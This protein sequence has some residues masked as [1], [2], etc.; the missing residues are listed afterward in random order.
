MHGQGA[1]AAPAAAPAPVVIQL[2][3]QTTAPAQTAGPNWGQTQQNGTRAA[4]AGST[5][6]TGADAVQSTPGSNSVPDRPTEFQQLVV[7]TTGT[8]LPVFGSD[9]F[10]NAPSTFAPV[11]SAQVTSDYLIGPGDEIRLSATGQLDQQGSFVV[12]RAGTI[13]IPQVGTLSVSGLHFSELQPFLKSQLGRIY[14]NFD[15]TVTLGQLRSIQIYV[16][17]EARRPGAYTVS[18]LSTLLNALFASGGVLP[19]GTL[20][21]IQLLRN[22][23]VVTRFDLYDILLRGD[24]SHDVTLQPGD[25]I[26]IPKAGPQVAVIGSVTNPAIYEL[27]GETTVDRLLAL[28]NGLTSTAAGTNARIESIYNHQQHTITD[29]DLRTSATTDLRDGDILTVASVSDEFKDA[30]TLRGNVTYPGRY[31]W[32]AG[33]R[34]SDLIR[35]RE[36]LRT[37]NY[38]R[39]LNTLGQAGGTA[40]PAEGHLAVSTASTGPGNA[41]KLG[42]SASVA[43]A[44]DTASAAAPAATGRAANNNGSG[45][46]VGDALTQNNG[47]FP[48][49]NDIVLSAPDVDLSYAVIER[50]DQRSLT[51]SLIPFNLGGLLAGDASQNLELQAGDVVTVFSKADIRVPQSQQTRFVRLEGEF[52][53]SG[54]YSVLPGETLRQLVAR[55]GGLT[56]DAYLY[57]SEF[58]RE[59]TRRVEQQRLRE[60]ADTLDAQISTQVSDQVSGNATALGGFDAVAQT[61][62]AAATGARQLVNRLRT[63]QPSGRI[64]LK[65]KPDSAGLQS[66]PDIALEDGDRFIIPRQPSTIAVSGQVYNAAAFLYVPGSE[67]REYLREAGGPQRDA[68]EKRMFVVRADGSVVSR[69]YNKVERAQVFPG[70]TVIVP[71]RLTHSNL[72]RNIVLIGALVGNLS[73]PLALLALLRN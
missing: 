22:N 51:T 69:Q 55:A 8:D 25:I 34:L 66:I 61:A 4:A 39:A 49:T 73:T 50:L 17:G 11:E 15:L 43:A 58:T 21:D 32:R 23:K 41:P 59:S 12:D 65:L 45:T 48:A 38:F 27:K 14:R 67:V 1:P 46:T 28:S 40:A 64:V 35:N 44:G 10:R 19:Q 62:N 29:L 24:K 70:D 37:R 16:T 31:T 33:M 6:G 56:P 47:S 30:V 68:D 5:T 42:G 57:A 26:F 18:S 13:S 2:P 54:I 20:R 72:L 71:P 60:Y 63:M 52:N 36:A 9:L 3:A 53:S 7:Q